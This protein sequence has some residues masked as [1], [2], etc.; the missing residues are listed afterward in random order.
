M[1]AYSQFVSS[2]ALVARHHVVVLEMKGGQAL[3]LPTVSIDGEARRAT[4]QGEIGQADRELAGWPNRC[5][6]DVS[7]LQW[8]PAS[9]VVERPGVRLTKETMGA[10]KEAAKRYGP[11]APSCS[12]EQA[13]QLALR[14]ARQDKIRIAA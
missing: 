10:L 13:S 2:G 11:K 6:F 12:E 4:V 14:A 9:F 8:V 1:L 3:I 7:A 5:K